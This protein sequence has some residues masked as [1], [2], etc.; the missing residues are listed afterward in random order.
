MNNIKLSPCPFCG[1]TAYLTEFYE[2]C[3]GRYDRP[4][5]IK[6]RDCETSMIL[7]PK[8]FEN[9][10]TKYGYT[11]GYYSQNKKFWDGMHKKIN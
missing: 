7:T 11:G 10:Q 8:E 1:G 2:S 3:D 5:V 4:A 9:V 6:C